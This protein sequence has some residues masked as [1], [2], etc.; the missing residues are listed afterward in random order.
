MAVITAVRKKGTKTCAKCGGNV[1]A[2]ASECQNCGSSELKKSL[3]IV[4]KVD[5]DGDDA[6]ATDAEL[7]GTVEEEEA[8]EDDDLEEDD[9]EPAGDEDDDEED[10]DSEEDPEEDDDEEEDEE[11]PKVTKR[12]VRRRAVRKSAGGG[13]VN[14]DILLAALTVAEDI[15]KAASSGDYEGEDSDYERAMTAFNNVCD[16]GIESWSSGDSISKES[17][18][19]KLKRLKRKL[20]QL[21]AQAG[22]D[23]EDDVEKSDK[24]EDIFKGLTPKAT[25]ILKAAQQI[26]EEAKVKEFEGIAKSFGPLPTSETDL[27]SALRT[28]SEANTK[29]YETVTKALKAAA[30]ASAQ[31]DIFKSFGSASQGGSGDNDD[32][33]TTIAKSYQAKNSNLTDEQAYAQALYDNPRLYDAALTRR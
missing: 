16:T 2:S 13:N 6:N 24:E 4:R 9:F 32:E 29:A 5:A 3:I 19:E 11:D 28:L 25:A 22:A 26:Q 18:E 33:L 17:P 1:A 7:E 30:E 21:K 12:I 10:D 20:A 14:L 31:S 27:G 15:S 8:D 23:D